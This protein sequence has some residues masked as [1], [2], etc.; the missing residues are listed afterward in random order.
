MKAIVVLPTYN[1]VEN[2]PLILPQIL[3][4][5]SAIDV[6]VVDDNSPDGTG[7]LADSLAQQNPRI[8]VLHRQAKEGLGRAYLAGFDWALQHNYT[9][10]IEMDADFSHNPADLIRLLAVVR[11]GQA[12]LALGSRW[13]KGGKTKNW[14][15]LRQCI[16]RCGSFYAGLVLGTKVRDITGGFKCF[17]HRVLRGI[18]LETVLANG[19]AFQVE[20]TYRTLQAGFTVQEVPI[21][22]KERL[23]GQSKMSGKIVVEALKVVWQLRFSPS[24]RLALALEKTPEKVYPKAH[25]K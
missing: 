23:H 18:E 13:S 12:D 21:T 5:D 4:Q 2:L 20:L 19:Y 17:H 16:S 7:V 24:S 14:S 1:E 3:A 22:F 11:E 10:I 9:Y 15:F 8:K 6:L 25:A